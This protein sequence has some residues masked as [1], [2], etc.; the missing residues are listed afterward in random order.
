[1]DKEK[2]KQYKD[3]LS[4][5]SQKLISAIEKR[6]ANRKIQFDFENAQDHKKLDELNTQKEALEKLMI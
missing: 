4:E 6:I 5:D 3:K 2:K 1:M